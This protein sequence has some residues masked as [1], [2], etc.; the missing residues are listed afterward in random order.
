MPT[1]VTT[2]SEPRQLTLGLALFLFDGFTR[3]NQLVGLYGD[4]EQERQD[5]ALATDA[6]GRARVARYTRVRIANRP[7]VPRRRESDA[8]FLFFD[9]PPGAYTFEAR[10]PYYA[11]RDVALTLPRPN[12]RWPAY[13]DVTLANEALPLDSPAQPAAYRAQRASVTLQPTVR[14]PFPGGTTLVRGI[15]R[16]GG[17]PLEGATVRRQGDPGGAV[18]DASGEFVLFFTDIGGSG[19]NVTLE[20]LHPLH[21]TVTASVAL[22]RG[23]TVLREFALP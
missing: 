21:A 5:D 12:P 6:Q 20:A 19:Q 15:V 10:S 2:F 23:L 17:L 16:T 4:R 7:V 18:T 22:V 14:Y 3:R 9:L 11:P 1:L 13:P 8:T